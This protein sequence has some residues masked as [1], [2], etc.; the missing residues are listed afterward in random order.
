M[1]AGVG[2]GA[3]IEGELDDEGRAP[4]ELVDLCPV[5]QCAARARNAAKTGGMPQTRI[6]IAIVLSFCK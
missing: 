5:N 2:R 6:C 3:G 4:I 1:G